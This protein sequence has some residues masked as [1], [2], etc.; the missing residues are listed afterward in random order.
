MKVDNWPVSLAP[1]I[2]ELSWLAEKHNLSEERLKSD[3]ALQKNL[4]LRMKLQAAG[5]L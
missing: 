5:D 2:G 4:W 1:M 3:L